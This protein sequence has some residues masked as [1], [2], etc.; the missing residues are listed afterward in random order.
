VSRDIYISILLAREP[1]NAKVKSSARSPYEIAYLLSSQIY[2]SVR[3]GDRERDSLLENAPVS[4][5]THNSRRLT[6]TGQSK[7]RIS[8]P[9]KISS[10]V[11]FRHR[12]REWHFLMPLDKILS[13]YF[14]HCRP[15]PAYKGAAQLRDRDSLP[16]FTAR[17]FD[18]IRLVCA[19]LSL[20]KS[21]SGIS[22]LSIEPRWIRPRRSG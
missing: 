13:R 2:D 7:E 19:S 18:K 20:M 4:A 3:K 17:R 5:M 11:P 15:L 6:C 12:E 1:L 16:E 10:T 21:R 22:T 9:V 14:T 8:I